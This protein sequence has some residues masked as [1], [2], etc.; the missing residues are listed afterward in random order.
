MEVAG[1]RQV[2]HTSGKPSVDSDLPLSHQV[3]S[4][5]P[6]ELLFE[7]DVELQVLAYAELGIQ[8]KRITGG[9][10]AIAEETCRV[11]G[12]GTQ[13]LTTKDISTNAADTLG[14]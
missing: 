11:I 4:H 14:G 7:A 1:K 6:I 9:H 3:G 2:C 5:A 10:V 8:V 12:M 13:I